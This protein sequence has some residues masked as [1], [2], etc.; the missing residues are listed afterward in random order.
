MGAVV[1][2]HGT[3]ED[4]S[5]YFASDKY[6]KLEGFRKKFFLAVTKIANHNIERIRT[7]LRLKKRSLFLRLLNYLKKLDMF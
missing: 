3:W 5:D 4:A 2:D 1:E 7:N 6:L